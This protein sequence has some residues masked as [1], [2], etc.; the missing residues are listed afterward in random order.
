MR[1]VGSIVRSLHGWT[2]L[3][4]FWLRELA[5][6]VLLVLGLLIFYQ[7][8]AMLVNRRL[9]EVGPAIFLGFIVFRAGL[10]LLKVSAAALVC[11]RAQEQIDRTVEPAS[12]RKTAP[13]TRLAVR[14]GPFD[15]GPRP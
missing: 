11:L 9:L 14:P 6:W 3:L 2:V 7:C 8:F 4:F 1:H 10:Q 5:G 12:R 15:L 13:P